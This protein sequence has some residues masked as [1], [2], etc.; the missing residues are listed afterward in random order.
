MRPRTAAET[1]LL[2]GVLS[3]V[4]GLLHAVA[5]SLL[6]AAVFSDRGSPPA[7]TLR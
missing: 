4:S 5:I 2:F 1:G 3:G 7:P 6:V